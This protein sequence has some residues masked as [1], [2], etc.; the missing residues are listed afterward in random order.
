M[1][2]GIG[3]NK[4]NLLINTDDLVRIVISLIKMLG[5]E[6]EVRLKLN[7]NQQK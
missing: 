6:N 7:K 1:S 3:K 4:K 5:I 2:N